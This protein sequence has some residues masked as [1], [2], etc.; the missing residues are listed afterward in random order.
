MKTLRMGEGRGH[1]AETRRRSRGGWRARAAALVLC[2]I[3][4]NSADAREARWLEP[5]PAPEIHALAARTGKPMS[6]SAE[7]GRVVLLSFGYTSCADICPTTLGTMGSVLQRLG[8]SAASVRAYYLSI[9]PQRDTP[10][11]LRDF[12]QAF[13]PRIEALS[14]SADALPQ[15]LRGYDVIVS[16]RPARLEHYLGEG[17]DPAADY[18][19]D[20]TAALWLIDADGRLRARL[21]HDAP[22]EKVARAIEELLHART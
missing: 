14:V 2:A 6:L 17:F 12:M 1:G 21:T 13:D 15:V 5:A 8:S 11:R 7:R 22:A 20:H 10:E 4:C 3:G 16:R 9:D 19:I 18:S